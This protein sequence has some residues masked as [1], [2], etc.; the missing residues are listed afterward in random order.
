MKK[1]ILIASLI[2]VAAS[3]AEKKEVIN[4]K[5]GVGINGIHCVIEPDGTLTGTVFTMIG[6]REGFGSLIVGSKIL[7][8]ELMHE[9]SAAPGCNLQKLNDVTQKAA[10]GF[11]FIYDTP[12]ELTKTT[13]PS[14]RFRDGE[15][16]AR[17]EEVLKVDLGD[18][19]V[20]TSTESEMRKAID[21][22]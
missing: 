5:A 19:L 16:L 17:Y 2:S 6:G 12:I 8:P 22:P 1:L 20:L 3:A 13:G 4:D 7:K 11:G 21:C 18:G 14:E 15:C 10:M 9:V